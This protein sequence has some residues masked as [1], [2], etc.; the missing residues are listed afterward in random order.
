MA[1]LLALALMAP[2]AEAGSAEDPEITDDEGDH[3]NSDVGFAG[4]DIVAA[5]VDNE[6][7]DA[8]VFVIQVSGN[9]AGGTLSQHS[10]T[11]SATFNGT[12]VEATA[13]S[14]GE[15]GGGATEATVAEPLVTL[16]VPKSAFGNT[17]PG[18]NLTG[19][20]VSAT[21]QLAIGGPDASSD[22]GP[23]D[24]TGRDYVVGSQA[25]GVDSDGDGIDDP[26]ELEQGTDPNNADTDGDGLTDGDEEALGTNATVADTD[27][28]G[29][30]DG[31]EVNV[32][33]TDPL[34]ADSD[35]DGISDGDEV[36]A[37][38][39]PTN[40]DSDGDGLSDSE[41][42]TLGTDPNAADS[43]GDGVS[44][45]EEVDAG[46]D[47]NDSTSVPEEEEE[48]G[49]E[50]GVFAGLPGD[51]DDWF[52]W[53][54]IGLIVFAIILLILW[55]VARRRDREDDEEQDDEGGAFEADEELSE[56]D[57][58]HARRIFEEREERFRRHRQE[59]ERA[60]AT[61]V[62]PD[63]SP[64]YHPPSIQAQAGHVRY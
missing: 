33:G 44:D 23:D 25:F 14:G 19:L 28:D 60:E 36:D 1:I 35:G 51:F 20:F 56:E 22:R 63:G 57:L 18:Q 53:L 49:S 55:L 3:E 16:T 7:A 45:K 61:H 38:T 32:H 6:T 30:S 31:A 27:G 24:G 48:P 29:L 39:D 8:F 12:T 47:P 11:F 62:H 37:G 9:P 46:S 40:A 64:C 5:W 52:Y 4:N 41:E 34:T 54:I 43:D 17:T 15:A 2:L 58:E 26:T 59:S 21:G 42:A 13:T 10:F 50:E